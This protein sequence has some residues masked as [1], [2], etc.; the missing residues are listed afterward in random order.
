[1]TLTFIRQT[2]WLNDVASYTE[3]R[4]RCPIGLFDW[5]RYKELIGETSDFRVPCAVISGGL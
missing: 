5:R 4:S 2:P 3:Y 1:M